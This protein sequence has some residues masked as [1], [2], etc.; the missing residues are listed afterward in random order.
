MA[1]FKPLFFAS[2][3]HQRLWDVIEPDGVPAWSN[4]LGITQATIRDGWYSSKKPSWPSVNH[5]I[6][7]CEA[8]ISADWLLCGRGGKRFGDLPANDAEMRRKITVE[9]DLAQKCIK[10]L[11]RENERLTETIRQLESQATSHPF[12]RKTTGIK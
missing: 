6:K 2:D 10:L 4:R 3:F 1:I 5:I 9:L 7:M 12:D 11:E 8:G